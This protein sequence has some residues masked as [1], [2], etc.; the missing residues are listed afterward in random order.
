VIALAEPAIEFD[1]PAVELEPAGV[2]AEL[3][4]TRHV[5]GD[6]AVAAALVRLLLVRVQ[7]RVELDVEADARVVRRPA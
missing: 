4:R 3:L 1:A 2:A 5:L 6:A 7:R